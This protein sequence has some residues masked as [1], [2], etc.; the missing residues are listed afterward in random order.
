MDND[1]LM[2]TQM[3]LPFQL[4]ILSLCT[5]AYSRIS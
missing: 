2:A 1:Y 5:L 4:T 3:E